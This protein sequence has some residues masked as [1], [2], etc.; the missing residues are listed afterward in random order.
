MKKQ[1][2]VARQVK[3]N[4]QLFIDQ[5]VDIMPHQMKAI[6]NWKQDIHLLIPNTW[7]NDRIFKN[8][9]MRCAKCHMCGF[10]HVD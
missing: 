3:C 7:E 1:Q 10:Y 2:F 6:G 9:T 5:C 4:V 8:R